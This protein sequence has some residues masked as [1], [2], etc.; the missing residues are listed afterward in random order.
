M[1]IITKSSQYQD[2]KVRMKS[3]VIAYL[4]ECGTISNIRIGIDALYSIE[5]SYKV[6]IREC[7]M[8]EDRENEANNSKEDA[9]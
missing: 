5:R 7:R 6:T 4:T 3:A 1:S 8:I 9:E 2:E